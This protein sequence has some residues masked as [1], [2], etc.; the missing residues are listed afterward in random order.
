MVQEFS[1]NLQNR[2]VMQKDMYGNRTEF[3]Y[4]PDGM[5]RNVR[6]IGD[7]SWNDNA[8]GGSGHSGAMA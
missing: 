8:G 5:L 3:T 4:E 6:R 7:G 2:P 1:Y